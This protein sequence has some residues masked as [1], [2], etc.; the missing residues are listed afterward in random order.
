MMVICECF[1]VFEV[2]V[3]LSLDVDTPFGATEVL[4]R[5]VDQINGHPISTHKA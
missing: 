1:T 5:I 2:S 3:R 4:A